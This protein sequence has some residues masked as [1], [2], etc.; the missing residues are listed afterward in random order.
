MS[1]ISPSYQSNE[2]AHCR[3]TLHC[4][5]HVLESVRERTGVGNDRL[6]RLSIIFDGGIGLRGDLCGAIAGGILALN[7]LHGFNL[8][9]MGYLN[10]FQKFLIGHINLFRKPSSRTVETFSIGKQLTDTFKH[11]AGALECENI[12]GRNFKDCEDFK[13]FM[14]TSEKCKELIRL[15]SDITVEAVLHTR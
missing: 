4:A 8:R 6:E 2:D 10:N 12:I 3:N 9:Q 1:P 11:H 14:N 5:Q 7:L 15:S 13:G